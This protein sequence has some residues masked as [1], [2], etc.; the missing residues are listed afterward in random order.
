MLIN[1]FPRGSVPMVSR[2]SVIRASLTRALSIATLSCCLLPAASA[3]TLPDRR[4]PAMERGVDESVAP[5]DDFFA[6]ANGDWLRSIAIPAGKDRW[7]ARNEIEEL[8]SHRVAE[9]LDRARAAPSGSAPRKVADYRAAYMDEAAIEARGLAPIRPLLDSIDRIR[10]KASLTRML[11]AGLRADVDPL[12]WGVYNSS[13]VLG[14]SV[15]ESI[16]GERSYVAFLVQGGLGLPDREDYLSSDSTRTALRIAY[17]QYIGRQ[18]ALMGLD[19]VDERAAAVMMLETAL[20]RSHATR[21]SSAN[22][23]NADILWSRAELAREA[24]GIDWNEFF[25]AARL[26]GQ[27]AFVPWQ[28]SALRGL[29]ALVASQPIETWKDYLRVHVIE[30]YADV[31]PRA[32]AEQAFALHATAAHDEGTQ[33]PRVERAR[34]ATQLAMG[35][36]IGRMYADRYFPPG[37]K[38]RVRAIVANVTAAF[39]RRVEAVSWMAPETKRLALAK[40]KT[41]Y[42]G[43]G[44]PDHWQDYS[45]LRVDSAD[46]LGNLRRVEDRN[47]RR[48]LS[49]RGRPIDSAEWLMPVQTPGALL[50]FQQNLYDFSAALLQS[51]KFD[52]AASD[53]AAYGAIGAIIGHDVTHFVDVLGAEY[54]A[55]GATRH[56][57]TSDDMARFELAARPLVDQFSSYQ[58]FSDV[59]VDGRLTRTENVADLGGLVA[60]FDAYRRAL[61]SKASNGTYVRQQD[62]EFFIAFARSWRSKSTEAGVRAQLKT[63]HAPEMFR[64]FTVRNLDAWYDAFDVRRGQALYVEPQARVRIW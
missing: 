50:V 63:D 16:H 3:Q 39:E 21:E 45:D 48:A 37:Q 41:L 55:R 28:P 18:L 44:Y 64:V 8:A 54:D 58:P 9:L 46:A 53:A 59:R 32:F 36:A 20:A 42:V 49:R 2:K 60:A 34:E 56:W 29:A 13:H 22:D 62:R 61:G 10:D 12:N 4:I 17:Q 51:P 38:S 33:P 26:S 5:G 6:Y 43:I 35:E 30:R 47:Y 25:A 23:H 7:N 31:L 1:A 40:L 27:E 14:L 19:R 15:E 24:P 52:S 57:W 11:G